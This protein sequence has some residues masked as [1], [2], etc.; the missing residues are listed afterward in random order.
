MPMHCVSELLP[1]VM[2]HTLDQL[3]ECHGN[4]AEDDDGCDHHVKLEDLGSIDDQITKTLSGGK[5]FTDDD[6]D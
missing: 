3:I 2:L 5:K 6:A 4:G 1:V